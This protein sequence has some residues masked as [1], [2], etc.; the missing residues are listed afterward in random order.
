MKSPTGQITCPRC[1]V[2]LEYLGT[3]RFHEGTR[4]WDVMGGLWEALKHREAFD[5]YVCAGCGHLELFLDGIGDE[6]RGEAKRTSIVGHMKQMLKDSLGA[7]DVPASPPM[8]AHVESPPWQCSRCEGMVPAT[9]E[10]CWRCQ[11]PRP[12]IAGT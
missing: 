2:P 5:V 9:F 3:K 7:G 8:T 1:D 11:T 12:G 6:A 4:F 10:M